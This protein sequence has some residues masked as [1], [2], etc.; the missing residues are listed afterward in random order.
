MAN[1]IV[2]KEDIDQIA[3]GID[4]YPTT[5]ITPQGYKVGEIVLAGGSTIGRITAFCNF[6]VVLDI[7]EHNAPCGIFLYESLSRT[8]AMEVLFG[9]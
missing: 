4:W 2:T 9:G 3:V 5:H 7:K 6:G 8:K 1:D